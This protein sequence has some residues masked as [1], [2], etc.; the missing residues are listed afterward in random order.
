MFKLALKNLAQNKVRLGLTMFAIVLGVGFV[1]SSFVLRDGLKEVFNEL[2]EQV[3][4]GVDI[5]VSAFD[6]DRDPVTQGDLDAISDLDGIRLAVLGMDGEGYENRLQP[7]K[8]DGETISLQG[9]PQLV[10][11]WIEDPGISATTV[12]DGRAP[13]N[14][15]EWVIDTASLE[16][17]G[18]VVGD[19]YTFVTP[20]GQ[21]QSE[22]VGTYTFDGFVEGPTFI[23]MQA[24]T[25]REWMQ[26]GERFDFIAISADGS[27]PIPDLQAEVDARLNNGQAR[28]LVQ[29]QAGLIADAQAGFNEALD[30][31]G[32]ILL[33]FAFVS[34]FVSIF[35]IA[36]TFAIT[37]SQRTRELGLLRAIGAT[38]RQ[39]LRSVVSESF[40]I[41]IIASILGIGAGIVIAFALR[42]ILNSIGLSIPSFGVVLQPQTIL[43]AFLVGT[44]VSVISAIVPAIGASR[45]S[46]IAAITGHSTTRERSVGRFVI[47]SII[48]ALGIALMALGLFGGADSVIGVLAPLGAGAMLLFIGITL[49][50]PLVAGPLSRLIGAPIA[51][52]FGTPGRLAQQ[53]SARNPRRTA[54]T[55]AALMIGLSLVSM[56]SVLGESFKAQFD[57]LLNTSVQADFI[58]SSDQTDIPDEVGVQIAGDPA[59]GNVS[60]VRYWGVALQNEALEADPVALPADATDVLEGANFFTD[61]GAFDYSQVDGLFNFDVIEGSL[62]DITN[63][64]VGIRDTV[65]EDLGIGLGDV[66]QL[67][68]LDG[69]VADLEVVSIHE[70]EQVSG[71]LLISFDRFDQVSPQRTNDFVAATVADGVSVEDAEESFAALGTEYPNLNFQSSAEFRQSFADQINFILNLLTVLL[72]LTIFIA[73]L[74]IANTLALSVFER[75]RE[76]GLLRAVGMSRRQNRRMIRWEA[77]II[78]AVGA[79]LGTALGV[80]LGVLMVQ[81]IPDEIISSFALPWTRIIIMAVVASLMG[82][83]AALFPAWRASRMNVLDAISHA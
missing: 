51:G 53:N 6:T 78:A 13:L 24:D 2:S 64:T 20:S 34:L 29:D 50:S 38:P 66:V 54:T 72:G 27:V 48:T 73:I 40:I 82:L 47:G 17:H 33:G 36:N 5:G 68:L 41:G 18:F 32:G 1:V 28:L 71:S 55:A 45:T 57:D 3:V 4:A 19:T 70:E 16:E 83:L 31:I 69:S 14:E 58:V 25:I 80:A 39:I 65:S 77:V 52:I 35:I 60:A 74:G 22:L 7:V 43:Y 15:D 67:I 10:F 76:I 62:E 9:P 44:L 49:L 8:P 42:A 75:T 81:A 30:I 79:V 11:S 63:E 21:Q 61:V 46:P 59:F 26:F 37:T 12:L 56:A 23:S